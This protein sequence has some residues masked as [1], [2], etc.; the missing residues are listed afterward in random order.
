MFKVTKRGETTTVITEQ[1]VFKI[2]K[3]ASKKRW[4]VF[5]VPGRAVVHTENWHG[6]DGALHFVYNISLGLIKI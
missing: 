4:Q 3:N 2:K 1:G 5:K 6:H